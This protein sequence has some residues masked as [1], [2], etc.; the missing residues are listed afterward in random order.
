MIQKLEIT[1]VHTTTDEELNRYITR[2][3]GRLDNYLPRHMRKVAH[4]EVK[5]KESKAKDKRQY[6]CEVTMYLPQDV[7]NVQEATVN[8]YAAVDIVEEKLKGQLKKYKSIHA[9]PELR[10]RII[11]RFKRR[12]PEI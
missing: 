5:L 9:S 8:M 11:T 6:V 3:I 7:I 2:K 10:R 12:G 1:G 4:V